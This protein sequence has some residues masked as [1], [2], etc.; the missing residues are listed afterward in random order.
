[1]GTTHAP[2]TGSGDEDIE[3]LAEAVGVLRVAGGGR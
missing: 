2:L 1:M 3:A